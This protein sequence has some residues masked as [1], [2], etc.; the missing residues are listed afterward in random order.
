MSYE[1]KPNSGTLFKNDR[2]D[3]G[4]NQPEYTGTALIEGREF[5][6][7]AWVKTGKNGRK[8][9]SFAFKPK[10]FAKE[11]PETISQRAVAAM[12]RPRGASD[13]DLDD[14]IPF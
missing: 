1:M 14:S 8:F 13:N 11:K 10:D 4:S 6:M 5:W 3:E 2:R 7:S 12:Q 9:F